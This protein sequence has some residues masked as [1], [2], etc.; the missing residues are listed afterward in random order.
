[1]I[2]AGLMLFG[3]YFAYDSVAAISQLLINQAGYTATQVGM[4][5][6]LYSWPNILG[7]VLI[8]GFLIDRFGTRVMSFILSGLVVLGAVIVAIAPSFIVLLI[9]RAVLGSGAEAMIVCQSVILA[10]WF[11]GKE[12]ALSF[13]LAL[14][15]M[16]LGSFA[17]LNLETWIANNYGGISAAFWFAAFM[18]IFSLIFVVYYVVMEKAAE[19]KV[20]LAEPP[21]G[22]KVT[23]SGPYGTFG[24]MDT[25]REMIFIGGGVGMAPLRAIIFDQL[26]RIG[27]SRRMSFWYGVRSRIDLFHIDDLEVLAHRYDNFR[28]ITALSDPASGDAWDGPTGFIHAVVYENYLKSHPAPEECEYYLCGPLLMIQSV[29]SMLDECGVG[30]TSIFFDDFGS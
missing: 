21:A 18:C 6:S 13:G 26:V 2:S 7:T 1:M 17:S 27:T 3:S 14:T 12:L 20:K 8:A 28:I 9:G 4:M 30:E 22:D 25:D 19:G 15:F 24:A 11:K 29:L 5:D 10:K 16:R 23:V